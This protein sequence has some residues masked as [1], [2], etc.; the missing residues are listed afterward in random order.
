MR[1]KSIST[2]SGSYTRRLVSW[3]GSRSRAKEGA[4]E[5]VYQGGS[6]KGGQDG[7]RRERLGEGGGGGEGGDSTDV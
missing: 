1:R 6:S 3:L 5:E 4:A 2:L 7:V